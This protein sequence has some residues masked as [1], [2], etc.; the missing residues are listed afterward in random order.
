MAKKRRSIVTLKDAAGDRAVKI[1]ITF[2][3]RDFHIAWA[4]ILGCLRREDWDPQYAFP[5]MLKLP[6]RDDLLSLTEQFLEAFGENVIQE[7]D[8]GT[9]KRMYTNYVE[10]GDASDEFPDLFEHFIDMLSDRIIETRIP[11][12]KPRY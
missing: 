3:A 9:V 7:G 1:P 12:L 8:F 6:S 5:E 10:S 2:Y 4:W 11:G